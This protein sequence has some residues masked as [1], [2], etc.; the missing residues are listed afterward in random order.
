MSTKSVVQVRKRNGS[1]VLFN[2]QKIMLAISKA[3]DAVGELDL[4]QAENMGDEAVER[5]HTT[6][7]GKIPSVEQVQDIVEEVLMKSGH[8]KV[9][10]A[11]ILYR[12]KRSELR[13][14]KR[15]L[16]HGAM[17]EDMEMSLNA[18]Q[19]LENRYLQ[20]DENGRLIETPSQMFRRV[21][22]YVAGGDNH[23]KEDPTD[24]EKL[25]YSILTKKQF[26]PTSP[27]L[28][29]AGTANKQLLSPFAIP[30]GD[31]MASIFD[32]VKHAALVHQSGGG[33]GFSFS[34]LRPRR[35]KVGDLSGVSS[36]PLSF[37]RIFQ[38]SI[39]IIKQGGKR[40]GANMGVLRVDHPDIMEF[41]NMKADGMSMPNFNLSVGITDAFMRAVKSGTNYRLINPRTQKA[42]ASLP[43]RVVFDNIIAMAWRNG[44]PGLLF[45]D[46]INKKHDCAHLGTIETT[47]P[48]GEMPLLPFESAAEGAINLMSMIDDDKIFNWNRLKTAVHAAVHFLDNVIT[49]NKY[50][51]D[52]IKEESLKT[53]KI[54]LGIMGFAD[55]LFRMGI[56]YDS[57]DGITW[58]KKIMSFI[59]KEG[60]AA[61]EK[62]A[63]SR[64]VFPAW[65]GSTFQQK[66]R[67]MRNATVTTILPTGSTSLIADTSPCL[68]P[69]FALCFARKALDG[70]EFIYTNSQFKRVLE[71]ENLYSDTLL[72]EIAK[73]GTIQ[74]LTKIPKKVRDVFVTAQDINAFW[75]ISM[76][77]AFQEFVDGAIS[78]TI[79]FSTAA[80]VKDVEEGFLLAWD[81][82]C[83]GVTIYRDGSI[84]S[85]IIRTSS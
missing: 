42:V 52:R 34:R 85:Q 48:C 2:K 29:N 55:A 84:D 57:E 69:N 75:H 47:S 51:L 45:L 14:A 26:F 21:A 79:N 67:R 8:T 37:M 7:G 15:A 20:R 1:V 33:T 82:G 81:K 28:M 72:R 40:Q 12:H 6:L 63:F 18:L 80:T 77:A 41:I 78:K 70:R 64:G 31:D 62:L 65:K 35:D 59:Q 24:T 19:I 38:V 5:I 3:M 50:P 43:A 22:H 11:Y 44:E 66:K 53:R 13:E 32:A 39:D 9:A 25:F 83:K 74:G 4:R 76:Q 16:L 61:S 27:T 56:K 10:K 60:H 30:I 58:A 54:G 46:R 17:E 36:G 23:Y 49:L 73:R 68:E 71:E